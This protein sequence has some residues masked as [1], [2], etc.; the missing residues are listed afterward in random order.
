MSD[1]M[2]AVIGTAVFV[3]GAVAVYWM[4]ELTGR[5]IR[6]IRDGRSLARYRAE[7]SNASEREDIIGG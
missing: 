6:R 7:I 1:T 4:L 5:T 2:V 3:G